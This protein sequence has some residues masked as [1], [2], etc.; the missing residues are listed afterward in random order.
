[1]SDE[2]QEIEISFVDLFNF[3]KR[4]LIFALPLALALAI[5]TY[6]WSKQIKPT[7]QAQATVIAYKTN[8]ELK[9][10]DTTLVTAPP[11]DASAYKEA[12]LSYPLITKVLDKLGNS[13]PSQK[14][15]TDLQ[16]LI[17]V[18]SEEGRSSSSI[19]ISYKD[20]QAEYAAKVA[21]SLANELIIWENER[22]AHG[23]K[24]IIKSLKSQ[25]ETIKVQIAQLK[26]QANPPQSEING[27]ES[28]LAKASL[29]MTTAKTLLNSA[30]GN[31]E[32]L[33]PARAPTK[34][35]SPRPKLN[36][37]LALILGLFLTYGFLLLKEALKTQYS[38]TEEMSKATGKSILAEFPKIN[39]G[40]RHLPIE[41]INY[42]RTSIILDSQSTS[43][44]GPGNDKAFAKRV[45]LITSPLATEGK[46]SVAR[47]LAESFSR[48]DYKTLLIDADL[49]KP[50]IA[51]IYGI[52][53]DKFVSLADILKNPEN[54]FQPTSLLVDNKHKLDVIPTFYP[55]ENA[56]ELLSRSFH[57]LLADL[58]EQ[59]DVIIVDS[60]PII[61]VAD[62]LTIAP[63]ATGVILI[64]SMRS[65]NKKSLSATIELLENIGVNILGI[66][67]T[68]VPSNAGKASGYGY[69]YGYGSGYG[70][71]K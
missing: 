50:V 47:G 35:V 17:T 44:L 52:R 24:K 8:N 71:S 25:I 65:G 57:A 54:S 63:L 20:K 60:A 48:N 15:I 34:P 43:L 2:N 59:Y 31:L 13:A 9:Q 23:P 46:S 11:I 58:R 49:R 62:T 56:T 68:N 29:Q 37:A 41:P 1:M 10:F 51:E 40:N 14:E 4:G 39:G 69:G 3:I 28:N 16:K 18:R 67:A 45:F 61:P 66:A 55:V 12:L 19:K 6:F 32:L 38:S 22:A 21:N 30:I 42:L 64:S 5:G 27:L 26:L 36:A 53:A 70:K 33:S 7:Y